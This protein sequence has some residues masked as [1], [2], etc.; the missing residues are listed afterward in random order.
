MNRQIWALTRSVDG[1]KPQADRADAIQVGIVGAKVFTRDLRGGVDRGT[2]SEDKALDSASF[3][4]FKK[5]E[6]SGD[7][8]FNIELRVRDRRPDTSPGGEMYDCV[9]FVRRDSIQNGILI[10]EIDC[11]QAN[12]GDK[13]LEILPFN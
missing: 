10:S 2:R 12:V 5:V 9:R 8:G 6:R 11:V 4:S 7:V 1:K 3:R 13:C